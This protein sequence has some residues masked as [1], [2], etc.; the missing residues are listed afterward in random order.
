[1]YWFDLP[2]FHEGLMK[3]PYFGTSKLARGN[4]FCSQKEQVRVVVF[5]QSKTKVSCVMQTHHKV[6][7]FQNFLKNHAGTAPLRGLVSRRK[8]EI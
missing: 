2:R 4:N 5:E 6:S 7:C 8:C 3:G 1:M